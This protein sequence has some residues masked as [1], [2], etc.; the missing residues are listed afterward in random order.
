MGCKMIKYTASD[1][2]SQSYSNDNGNNLDEL[3]EYIIEPLHDEASLDYL[4]NLNPH[5][6]EAFLTKYDHHND[7]VIMI[8]NKRPYGVKAATRHPIYENFPVKA[9]KA[10]L[11]LVS[12]EEQPNALRELMYQ[13]HYNYS[14][15]GLGSDWM[16]RLVDKAASSTEIQKCNREIR[17]RRQQTCIVTQRK[18]ETFTSI[19]LLEAQVCAGTNPFEGSALGMSLLEFFAEAG[20]L[21]TMATTHHG[22]LKTLKYRILWGIPGCRPTNAGRL[23]AI[24]I[25]ERLG[26]PNVVVGNARELHG[27]ASAKINEADDSPLQP[28]M[29]S[30]SSQ[31]TPKESDTTMVSESNVK[32]RQLERSSK[33]VKACDM[34]HVSKFDKKS[35]CVESDM[36]QS[37]D[38]SVVPLTSMFLY[39]SVS[40][41]DDGLILLEVAR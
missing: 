34:V 41:L 20:A 39:V 10:L 30:F 3:E 19:S 27:T 31:S 9:F 1:S 28:K 22:E 29:A 38:A 35:R 25:A 21:L 4:C 23:N 24:N 18:E 2:F 12:L 17:R 32:N 33:V 14:A 8:D 7:P 6:G 26:L 16:D 37:K 40:M 15:C 5:I 36:V 11:A 13:C